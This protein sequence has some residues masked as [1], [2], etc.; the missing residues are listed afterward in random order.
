MPNESEP[1]THVD[2]YQ[3]LPFDSMNTS[4]LIRFLFLPEVQRLKLQLII[5]NSFNKLFLP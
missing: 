5:F 3:M 1:Y 4:I 2:L